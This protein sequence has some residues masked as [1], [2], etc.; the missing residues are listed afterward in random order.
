VAGLHELA[1][2]VARG[3]AALRWGGEGLGS[4]MTRSME[5][6]ASLAPVSDAQMGLI[7]LAQECGLAATFAGSGGAIVGVF[8]AETDL[9]SLTHRMDD[10]D[11]IVREVRPF[12]F[13]R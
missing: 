11:A 13:S 12:A 3:K 5:I 7:E 8:H 10:P 1:G 4:L 2:L 6:R 9:E